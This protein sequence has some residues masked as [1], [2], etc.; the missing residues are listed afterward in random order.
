MLFLKVFNNGVVPGSV[1]MRPV[2]WGQLPESYTAL[3]FRSYYG[4]MLPTPNGI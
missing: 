2:G 3:A 4:L 1:E